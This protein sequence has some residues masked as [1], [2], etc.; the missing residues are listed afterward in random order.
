MKN[1]ITVIDDDPHIL[2]YMQEHLALNDFEVS[3]FQNPSEALD[4]IDE[5]PPALVITDVKMD[6]MT[7]DDV[8]NHM[9]KNHPGT[10]VIV[11]TGFG[12]ISHS[13]R[14]I[15]KGAFDYIT[16]PF[17]GREFISRVKQYFKA[18]ENGTHTGRDGADLL[19]DEITPEEEAEI[20]G[21]RGKT[22]GSTGSHQ[23]VGED[24][25]IKKLL[26]ILP[27]I[28]P[29]GAP[30][31]IQGES[32][33]GK[34]VYANLIQKNSNRAD[35]PFVKINCA[36]LPSD[37]VES[38]LFG[39]VKG[40]FTG[41]IEDREGAFARADGGTLL[42]DEVTEIDIS[43]QA[44]LLRVLQ[45]K[46][47]QKVGSQKPRKVDVRIIS[48]TN[49]KLGEAISEGDFRKDLYFRLNVFPIEMP[50]LRERPGDIPM[51]ARYFVDRYC[52]RYELEKKEISDELL[53][54]L[55]KKEW[56]GNVR[57]LENYVQRGIIM[58][59]DSDEI[60][61]EHIDNPLFRN[62][63]ASLTQEVINDIPVLPIEEMELQMIKKALERTNGN[64]K[65]AAK[66]LKISDRTIRNKLKKIE[67]P[68][69]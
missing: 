59:Q 3:A 42:L 57:E 21:K 20:S 68:E 53:N 18:R 40:A 17:S 15:R 8:L 67:F 55:R 1:K 46:E 11:I 22:G 25:S 45:E 27:Q 12:N 52:R 44:K 58:A 49:R 56:P 54:H 23:L 51:L 24:P 48:T 4:E 43:L 5:N 29:T 26:D 34:E 35:K 36:N 30:V 41:A 33:T 9:L 31:M 47:F 63:D 39:H 37:L 60:S 38:T 6:Q 19:P 62:V 7:G 13:V 69:E 66:L 14:S 2:N 10:G 16:K 65:E 64:Q 61:L 32:G 50:S 28:A